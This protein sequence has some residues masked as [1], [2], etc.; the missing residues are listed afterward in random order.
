MTCRNQR[1]HTLKVSMICCYYFRKARSPPGL[2][3]A[4]PVVL[5]IHYPGPDP[6][7]TPCRASSGAS[8]LPTPSFIQKPLKPCTL[9]PPHCQTPRRSSTGHGG[10]GP[11]PPLQ[12]VSHRSFLILP[13]R[14]TFNSPN[15]FFLTSGP[16]LCVWSTVPLPFHFWKVDNTA[17][18]SQLCTLHLPPRPG[19]RKLSLTSKI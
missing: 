6:A 14:S 8:C 7:S 16:G 17:L 12:P 4:L 13:Q 15:R 10:P 2:S 18:R 9:A 19:T 1:N 5:P 3:R 11:C